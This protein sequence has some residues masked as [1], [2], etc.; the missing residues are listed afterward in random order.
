MKQLKDVSKLVTAIQSGD[1]EAFGQLYDLFCRQVYRFIYY[2]VGTREDAEDLTETIFVKAFEKLPG[3]KD[4]GLP[5]EAWL[6]RVA[7]NEVI[8]FYRTKKQHVALSEALA[9]PD[10]GPTLMDRVEKIMTLEVV[11]RVLTTLPA[12]YQEIILL[13]YAQDLDNSEISIILQKPVS[14]I[15]VLQSRALGALRKAMHETE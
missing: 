1:T 6:F 3:Y 7:R 5:F 11:R 9:V 8:D 10:D 14:H 15:R 12:S 4:T 2:R 13:T